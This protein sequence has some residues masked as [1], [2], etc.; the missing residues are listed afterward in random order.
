MSKIHYTR[1]P[2][3]KTQNEKTN[4]NC[5]QKPNVITKTI[6]Y[7]N[8]KYRVKFTYKTAFKCKFAALCVLKP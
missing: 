2:V 3:T 1:Y 8:E 5:K 7:L 6:V 4:N